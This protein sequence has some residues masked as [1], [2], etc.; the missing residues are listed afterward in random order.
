ME[1]RIYSSLLNGNQNLFQ[2]IE[3]CDYECVYMKKYESKIV[4]KISLY[5][6][7][8]INEELYEHFLFK[9]QEIIKRIN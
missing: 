9:K 3:W 1:T 7:I 2:F 5:A 6:N 8:F 4:L